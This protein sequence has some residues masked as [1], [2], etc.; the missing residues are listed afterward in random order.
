MQHQSISKPKRRFQ[1]GTCDA[2]GCYNKC[3]PAS[4]T[5]MYS[6]S[7][8]PQK[9]W[10]SE[11]HEKTDNIP[12]LRKTNT[13]TGDSIGTMHGGCKWKLLLSQTEYETTTAHEC[14]K[15]KTTTVELSGKEEFPK[16]VRK[17]RVI[18]S[19]RAMPGGNMR[20]NQT[21]SRH[22]KLT[23]VIQLSPAWPK[24]CTFHGRFNSEPSTLKWDT[25]R[26]NT[27]NAT[28]NPLGDS[29]GT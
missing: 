13:T 16:N 4:L 22:I 9:H 23:I 11:R 24:V 15:Q 3:S 27:H 5:H 17:M 8:R 2:S 7:V 12:S 14:G 21:L 26:T 25:Q 6:N 19:A 18:P 1:K 28:I 29:N 20:K 10:S